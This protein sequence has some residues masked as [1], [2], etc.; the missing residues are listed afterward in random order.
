MIAGEVN[1]V[2]ETFIITIRYI[3]VQSGASMFSSTGKAQNTDEVIAT[4][5]STA[6]D[7]IRRII[8]EDKEIITPVLPLVYYS[9]SLCR[10]GQ[11]Y[12]G[13]KKKAGYFRIVCDYR[14]AELHTQYSIIKKSAMNTAILGLSAGSDEYDRKYKSAKKA[15][16]LLWVSIVCSLIYA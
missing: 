10:M 5:E 8:E 16:I 15:A 4:A 6:K 9:V 2:G 12:A 14:R 1:N 3:D 13:R 7:L 11:L